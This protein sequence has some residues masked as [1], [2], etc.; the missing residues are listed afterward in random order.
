VLIGLSRVT[1]RQGVQWTHGVA[2]PGVVPWFYN[3]LGSLKLCCDGSYEAVLATSSF[4][5][6]AFYIQDKKVETHDPYKQ[7]LR[8]PWQSVMMQYL[9]HQPGREVY[10][11]QGAYM[12]YK[13]NVI[14]GQGP[15]KMP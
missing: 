10:D 7:G 13:G 5:N 4:P 3:V 12:L 11:A 9:F 1:G 2:I 14:T 6:F 15:T 8:D